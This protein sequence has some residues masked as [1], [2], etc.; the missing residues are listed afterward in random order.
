MSAQ[1]PDPFVPGNWKDEPD[2]TT[3]ITSAALRTEFGRVASYTDAVAA[4]V[5]AVAGNPVTTTTIPSWPTQTSAFTL[6]S[7][8]SGY[9]IPIGYSSQAAVRFPGSAAPVS[10]NSFFVLGNIGPSSVTVTKDSDATVYPGGTLVLPAGGL[11]HVFVIAD[12]TFFI[13][14]IDIAILSAPVNTLAPAITGDNHVGSVLSISSY[15]SWN[16]SVTLSGIQWQD[17]VNGGASWVN[18]AGQ[19]ATTYTIGAGEVG[20]LVAALISMTASGGGGTGTALSNSFTILAAAGAVPANT[21]VP[22]ITGSAIPTGVLTSTDGVWTNTPS[23]RNYLWEKS[24]NGTTGWTTIR[25]NNGTANT[26]DSYTVAQADAGFFI[27][28]QVTAING[29]GP[30]ASPAISANTSIANNASTLA[31]LIVSD[32]NHYIVGG[33]STPLNPDDAEHRPIYGGDWSYRSKLGNADPLNTLRSGV[34]PFVVPWMVLDLRSAGGQPSTA[35]VRIQDFQLWALMN[36][37][38]V[39]KIYTVGSQGIALWNYTWTATSSGANHTGGGSAPDVVHM[40]PNP[41]G[42][43]ARTPAGF[44]FHAWTP[45]WQTTATERSQVTAMLVAIRYQLTANDPTATYEIAVGCDLKNS[46][47]GNITGAVQCHFKD[48]P[49]NGTFR[50]ATGFMAPATGD[51]TGLNMSGPFP[52]LINV[53]NSEM[54]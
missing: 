11:C 40:G 23:S 28:T 34:R 10:T 5:A 42:A 41:P 39:N 1:A 9:F 4:W 26:T 25:T 33:H 37:T 45:A 27:R 43:E 24:A 53:A 21:S 32:M 15:G 8:M 50:A 3:P 35:R 49:T 6:S 38:W 48:V 54:Y 13:A 30:S 22:V 19:T 51:G 31:T 2:H 52:A 16:T 17:S 36:G 20:R 12:N 29:A 46:S 7:S 47:Y 14:G 44:L 18:I